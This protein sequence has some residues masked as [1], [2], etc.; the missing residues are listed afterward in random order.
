M[1]NFIYTLFTSNPYVPFTVEDI[2]E[3]ILEKKFDIQN[4]SVFIRNN[5]LDDKIRNYISKFMD[6]PGFKSGEQETYI[7]YPDLKITQKLEE[8]STI[9]LEN[10][11]RISELEKQIEENNKTIADLIKRF[12]ELSTKEPKKR[13]FL[14]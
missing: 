1:E 14:F 3:A 12:E 5:T 11:N 9:I 8:Q 7:Y 4:I 2:R 6:E 13:F 10:K